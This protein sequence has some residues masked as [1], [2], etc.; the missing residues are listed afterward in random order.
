MIFDDQRMAGPWLFH[1][2]NEM[3]YQRGMAGVFVVGS[4]AE[5]PKV[6]KGLFD[7]YI[8]VLLSETQITST[9]NTYLV[10]VRYSLWLMAVALGM[11]GCALLAR[12]ICMRWKGVR[13]DG[14]IQIPQSEFACD[15][16]EVQTSCTSPVSTATSP[17]RIEVG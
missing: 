14:S 9:G 11:L 1:C 13:S 2:H 16:I 7:A 8:P 12:R 3:H 10:Y 15:V 4:V 5:Q 6:P 17:E